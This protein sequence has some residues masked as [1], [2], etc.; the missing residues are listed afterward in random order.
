M[1]CGERRPPSERCAPRSSDRRRPGR[2]PGASRSRSRF[3]FGHR[4]SQ[5]RGGGRADGSVRAALTSA[6]DRAGPG[7]GGR[8]RAGGVAGR[9]HRHHG[10]VSTGRRGRHRR[11]RA[12]A[13]PAGRD[14]VEEVDDVGVGADVD[15]FVERGSVRRR[16]R[17]RRDGSGPASRGPTPAPGCTPAVGTLRCRV[18]ACRRASSRSLRWYAISASPMWATP[19]AGGNGRRLAV[20]D[21]QRRPVGLGRR[22]E[23]ASGALRTERDSGSEGG[24]PGSPSVRQSST[25][26]PVPG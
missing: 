18:R 21:R 11:R 24:A 25:L 20:L 5:H 19:A 13:V 26:T 8:V 10:A 4:R 16:C 17:L 7:A 3:R 9:P 2:V 22:V 14:R 6:D 15:R 23:V 1:R 12:G